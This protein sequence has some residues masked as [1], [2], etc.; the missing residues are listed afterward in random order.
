MKSTPGSDR[1]SP[2][3]GHVKFVPSTRN[4][5]SLV[6]EPNADTLLV[7]PLPG[8]VAE[9]PGADLMKSNGPTRRVGI[10]LRSSGPKRVSIPLSR[11]SMRDPAPWGSHQTL[12]RSWLRQQHTRGGEKKYH[13][14]AH[15]GTPGSA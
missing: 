12:R 9:M 10:V 13:R 6:P 15:G 3:H 1:A 4:V 5:F 11:A 7:A 2:L 8:A 14:P